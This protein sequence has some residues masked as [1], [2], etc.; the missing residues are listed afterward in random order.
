MRERH[1]EGAVLI[2]QKILYRQQ[3]TL[4][5]FPVANGNKSQHHYSQRRKKKTKLG[6][7]ANLNFWKKINLLCMFHCDGRSVR[8]LCWDDLWSLQNKSHLPFKTDETGIDLKRWT[9][10]FVIR[11][12]IFK[13]A[14]G[15]LAYANLLWQK[16]QNSPIYVFKLL[17]WMLS[18]CQSVSLLPKG[19]EQRTAALQPRG[20][21]AAQKCT[22][23]SDQI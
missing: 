21:L 14:Y 19:K 4:F 10:L 9:L 6:R 11:Q 2:L 5:I 3:K 23:M 1:L 15:V 13:V 8:S 17:M 16:W 12:L 7:A 18:C 20:E 22:A